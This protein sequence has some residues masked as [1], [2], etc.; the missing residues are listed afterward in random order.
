MQEEQYNQ[1]LACIEEN[2]E[3]N[4]K[5]GT[6]ATECRKHKS[7]LNQD[8]LNLQKKLI[9]KSNEQIIAKQEFREQGISILKKSPIYH[10]FLEAEQGIKIKKED[11]QELTHS[12]NE[13]YTDFTL[14][15]L[16]LYPMKTIE[17]QVCLLIKIG[18]PPTQIAYITSHTKQ[19]ITSIRKGYTR[20]LSIWMEAPK[21]G[22]FSLAQCSQKRTCCVLLLLSTCKMRT[23]CV[24]YYHDSY[25][26]SLHL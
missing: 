14:R 19:A 5:T 12:I 2:R 17:M 24:L 13:A 11:W 8:L 7:S 15:L 1:S 20:R 3:A 9:E 10:K 16:D 21:I 18:V 6:I 22:I 25:T 26:K 4:K 23:Y